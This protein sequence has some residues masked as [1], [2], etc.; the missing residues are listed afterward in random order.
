[1]TT[2]HSHSQSQHELPTAALSPSDGSEDAEACS[3]DDDLAFG[4]VDWFLYTPIRSPHHRI[5]APTRMLVDTSLNE[6]LQ[7]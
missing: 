5:A 4:A 7:A 3:S 2:L 6:E 1:M